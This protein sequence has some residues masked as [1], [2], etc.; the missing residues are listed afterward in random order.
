M[1]ARTCDGTNESATHDDPDDTAKHYRIGYELGHS[2][3]D[4]ID[5]CE[6]PC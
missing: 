6:E 5:Q 2:F 3:S 1:A 4:E